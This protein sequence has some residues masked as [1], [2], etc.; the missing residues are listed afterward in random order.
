MRMPSGEAK[1]QMRD[2][3]RTDIDRVMR[4]SRRGLEEATDPKQIAL[5]KKTLADLVLSGADIDIDRGRWE[6]AERALQNFAV[7]FNDPELN[8][9]AMSK[10]ILAKVRQGKSDESIVLVN[11]LTEAV[12]TDPEKQ[13]AVA[14]MLDSALESL[15]DDVERLQY[16]ARVAAGDLA[17]QEKLKAAADRAKASEQLSDR[18]LRWARTRNVPADQ[19]FR[20]QLIKIQSLLL[21]QKK[22]E[23]LDAIKQLRVDDPAA[24]KDA[25]VV[26]M[27]AESLFLSTTRADLIECAKL[28]RKIT[29]EPRP[30]KPTAQMSPKER[31]EAEVRYQVWWRSWLRFLQILD[32]L[33]EHTGV[34]SDRVKQLRLEDED[35]GGPAFKPQFELLET[36]HRNAAK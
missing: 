5:F 3:I 23:A 13:A 2:Q 15:A 8:S 28:L 30:D 20:Y 22:Q 36:T 34:I 29:D 14:S 4:L 17:K 32:R 33:K 12:G 25:R 19:I 6:D 11:Q 16:E 9:L 35:L 24:G 7:D 27:E 1:N 31:A 10:L 26:S 18:L 21:N